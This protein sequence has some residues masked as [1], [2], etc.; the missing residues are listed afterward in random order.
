[1]ALGFPPGVRL[2]PGAMADYFSNRR[3]GQAEAKLDLASGRLA[4]ETYGMPMPEGYYKIL[5]ERYHIEVKRIAGDTDV[6]EK[7]MGHAKGYNEVSEPEIKRRFG[8]N[9]LQ[10]VEDEAFR[11][12]RETFPQ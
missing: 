2:L 7:V 4:I 1:M 11:K 3:T 12:E 6:T 10:S 8:D 9:V 5:R